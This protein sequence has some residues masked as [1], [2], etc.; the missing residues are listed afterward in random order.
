M[1]ITKKA[2]PR[3]TFLKGMGVT[4]ALP[5]LDAMVPALTAMPAAASVDRLVFTFIPMGAVM[6]KWTPPGEGKLSALSPILDS[7]LPFRDQ[8]TILTNLELAKAY[9][10]TG[11]DHAMSNS[12]FLS[13]APAKVTEGSDYYLATTA[14]QIAAQQM[15]RDT[16][17][18]SLE[19]G[20]D[21][22]AQ[23]GHC[24]D[25]LACAYQNNLSWSSPTTPLPTEA[26][27][28]TVFERLF[29]ERG[30]PGQRSADARRNRSIL[31]AVTQDIARLK[32]QVDRADQ[33][34]VS[35][36]FDTVRE[37][38]RRIQKAEEQAAD[39]PE[40][41]PERPSSILPLLWGDHVKLMFDLQVLAFQADITRVI[42][43]QLAREASSRTYPEIGVPDAHHPTS[44]HRDRPEQLEKLA[45]I[46]TYHMS[47]YAYFL[48][49]LRATPDVDGS[50][51]DHGVYMLGSGMGNPDVHDH[52]NL[53]ALVAGG[54]NGKLKGGRHIRY[55]ERTP[56]ANLHLTLLD[57]VGVKLDSF[58]DSA[59]KIP[60]LMEPISL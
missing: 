16:R 20:T 36:Y 37:V 60:E 15:G 57:K 27:P 42:T 49:K 34:H 1:I 26:D 24:D 54:G 39:S 25:G 11:A 43:F 3:R 14:D 56:M 21:L 51:L 22:I 5:F 40:V 55:A 9:G 44:H 29:G 30:T 19:L 35:N 2:L 53:P 58:G 47:L 10:P 38:E 41:N 45:K 4:A 46:N 17:L 48:E 33:V 28:R 32:L 13:C 52:R 23:V 8:L 7:L 6:A 50:L 18:P 12:T 31:D 59:G